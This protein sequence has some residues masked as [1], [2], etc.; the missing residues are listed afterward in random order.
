MRDALAMRLVQRIGD[1]NRDLQCLIQRYGATSEAL[2][3]RFTLE[4]FHNEKIRL[5]LAPDVV[6]SADVRMIQCGD[7]L[8][9]TFESL[10]HFG[11]VGKLRRQHLDR[12]R[13]IQAGIRRFVD[14]AHPA[15][16]NWRDD[17]VRS[18]FRPS[19]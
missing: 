19:L 5:L 16:A 18:K 13:A 9:F 3:E 11:I 6:Q 8:R 15:G 10:L 1:L 17:I 2:G 7:R 14:F 4:V 12:H